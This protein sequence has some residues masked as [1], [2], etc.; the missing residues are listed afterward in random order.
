MLMGRRPGSYSNSPDTELSFQLMDLTARVLE[1]ELMDA[2]DLAEEPHRR[3][4]SG[5]RRVNWWSRT[6]SVV[7]RGILQAVAISGFEMGRPLT[8]LDLACGG[9]D[10]TRDVGRALLSRGVDVRMEGWDRSATAIQFAADSLLGTPLAD[11][12]VF[13]QR[14]VWDLGSESQFDIVMCTLFLHHLTRAEAVQV[15]TR[16]HA[17]ARRLVLVDDLR[18][19]QLGYQL[20]RLGCHLLSRSQ[21]VHVDGPLSVRAAFTEAE[22]CELSREAGLKEPELKRHWPERFLAC[23]KR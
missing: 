4:L 18:R 8:I 16:M 22:I 20:A 6:G 11:K 3:A 23:W 13:R 2:P 12:L 19:S 5:L 14:D 17:A 21:I 15:L 9:G 1:G 7:A 10:V